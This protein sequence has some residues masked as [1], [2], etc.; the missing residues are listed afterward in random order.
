MISPVRL[1]RNELEGIMHVEFLKE[2]CM[3]NMN[4]FSAVN[5][6]DLNA[7]RLF[8]LL[9]VSSLIKLILC[10]QQVDLCSSPPPQLSI[11]C[12]F[13]RSVTTTDDMF[14]LVMGV[15]PCD[16]LDRSIARTKKLDD[17]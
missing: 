2:K 4:E 17:E 5:T 1:R 9:F 14:K 16:T 12:F 15:F 13:L 7:N 10:K 8:G 11:T 6:N 3:A